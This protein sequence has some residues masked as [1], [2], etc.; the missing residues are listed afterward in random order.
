MPSVGEANEIPDM[1]SFMS[2]P[3]RVRDFSSLLF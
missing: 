3:L 2:E 1:G